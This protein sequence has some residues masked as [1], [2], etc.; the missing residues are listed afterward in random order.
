[1]LKR[2][3]DFKETLV[4]FLS[5]KTSLFLF[6]SIVV[7][8]VAIYPFVIPHLYHPSMIYHILIHII[9]FDVALFL[10]TIS[11]VSFKK[12]KSKKILLTALSFGFLL[13][14][15]FLYLLQSSN[16]LGTFYIPLI[17]V[18]FPHILLL[19]MLG[20]FAAG[21]LKLERK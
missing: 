16:L 6:L 13:F 12:T 5:N 14:T 3:K 11:F 2:D 10:T 1:L 15:E 9:S 17:E 7:A 4:H 21:V 19:L 18:E 20:L 8:S